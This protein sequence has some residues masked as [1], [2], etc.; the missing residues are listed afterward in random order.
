MRKRLLAVALAGATIVAFGAIPA[1]ARPGVPVSKASVHRVAVPGG[2]R[3]MATALRA[4]AAPLANWTK[5]ASTMPQ[6]VYEMG[7]AALAKNKVY[8]PGGFED[9]AATTLYPYIQIFNTQNNTWSADTSQAMPAVGTATGW[10]DA[11]VCSDGAKTYVINGVDGSFL[12]SAMQIY[13]PTQPAG[14]RWSFGQAPNTATAGFWY[15][16]D[17]GCAWI[18]GKLYLFGGYGQSDT[19]PQPTTTAMIQRA[20]WVYDPVADTWSDT[21]FLMA[22]TP[23]NKVGLW[24]GYTNSKTAAF[25]AG[26]TD[27]LVNFTPSAFADTFKPATGW[28]KL[29]ALPVPAG[30]TTETG[31]IAPGMGL[32]GTNVEVFGGAG[33]DGTNFII[34]SAT[35]QCTG[36]C[37]AMSTWAD[38]AKDLNDPRWFM[39]FASGSVK[40]GTT[41]TPTL[42]AAGGLGFVN[43]GGSEVVLNSLERTA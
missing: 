42:F 31:L 5:A 39:G 2:V 43:G 30:A 10:G 33:F 16:Q 35:L 17:S 26:G 1:S 40:T 38:A 18:G 11:A 7:G 14:S 29:A 13:D 41:Q 12:Y 25:A 24:M 19:G 15:S 9:L 28:K 6:A 21:G 37:T 34:Q 22:Q 36:P 27:D 3:T 23:T 8:V 20:T 4:H 32:L